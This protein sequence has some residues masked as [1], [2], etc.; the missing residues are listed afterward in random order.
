MTRIRSLAIL[1]AGLALILA[2]CLPVTTTAPV[3]TTVGLGADP[4][5]IGTWMPVPDKDGDKDSNG[6]APGYFHFLKADDGT[7]TALLVSTGN[8]KKT[9]EW[10][11]Y[12]VTTASLG[13]RHFMNVRIVS[14]NGKADKDG[15][16]GN[17]PVLYRIDDDGQLS[18]YLIDEDK[19]KAAIADGK[20]DGT[21]GKGS[22][23]DAVMT[24]SPE[25]L[26]AFIAS[27]DGATLFTE[28]LVTLR[29]AE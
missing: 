28:K 13:G 22:S 2:G 14:D 15:E 20:I 18:L 7:L 9:G 4:A 10:S 17:I 26:D 27:D 19:A 3:G 29:R 6:D 11:L 21:I 16:L 1:C 8:A 24:A 23:G 25:T 12:H 5:L